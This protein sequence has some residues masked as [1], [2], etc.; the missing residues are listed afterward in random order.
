[1][2]SKELWHKDFWWGGDKQAFYTSMI[3][4]QSLNKPNP[5]LSPLQMLL[6]P[7]FSSRD[8]KRLEKTGGVH[9]PPPR[10]VVLSQHSSMLI[11]VNSSLLRED[12]IKNGML[13]EYFRITTSRLP[14]PKQEIFLLSSLWGPGEAPRGKTFKRGA[15]QDYVP[16][17]SFLT[18]ILV[19][20]EPRAVP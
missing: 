13:W 15:L 17:E 14:C 3:R 9:F 12:L 10:S 11:Q 16:L 19:H 5:R 8:Q 6:H 7:T 1:M 20:T 4:S 18:L 2:G